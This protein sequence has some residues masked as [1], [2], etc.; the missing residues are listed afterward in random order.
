[1]AARNET[2]AVIGGGLV[3]CLAALG[4]ARK[5]YPVT[6]FEMRGDPRNDVAKQGSLRSI[7]LAVS[8][9]G[10][11]ALKYVDE[12]M[13][14]RVLE[15]IIPMTGRMI[16][17]LA[18]NQESQQYGLYGEAINSIDRRQLNIRLLEECENINKELG[19]TM[20][21]LRFH[22]K[23]D[24]LKMGE[25]VTIISNGESFQFDFIVGCDGA[26]SATRSKLQK[27]VRMNYKQEYI[28]TCYVELSI[29][30]GPNG[31]FLID[32]NHLHIW[33]RHEFMLIA[34]ANHDRSFTSTF[35]GP[36]GLVEKN[37]DTGAKALEFFKSQFPDAL[38]IIG[39]ER[40][41]SAFDNHPRGALMQVNCDPY[42]FSD[43]AILLGDAAHSMVPFYGQ[44]MNCG[45]EDVRILLTLLDESSSGRSAAFEKY[46]EL[47]K[48]DLK[49]I[50]KLA[51]DNYK[52][53]SHKVVSP[54]FLLRKKVDALLCRTLGDRWLPL[55]TMVSFRGD[56]G[57]A[58]AIRR[59]ELH[60]RILKKLEFGALAAVIF[61]LSR[62][63]PLTVWDRVIKRLL[64]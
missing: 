20:V 54:W 9:R 25:K 46:T 17:D 7:N 8:D 5:G 38:K 21:D 53:M 23:L 47:R 37:L 62:L 49:A 59:E 6:V 42:H 27:H 19:K 57:Y 36:W 3:G 18:G 16:H 30:A 32:A 1:M 35:F 55:Y 14:Y 29:P 10:I 44:G 11:R 45:F 2:V 40:I 22:S 12:A 64:N 51:L 58:E 28:D 4:L 48:D 39:H 13:A 15:D 50:L 60:E 26:Y 41:V 33:P 43:K 34:L 56:I 31:E 61:G 24:D 52:E 63:V